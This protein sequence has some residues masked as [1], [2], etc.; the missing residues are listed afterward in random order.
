MDLERHVRENGL[1]GILLADRLR[2]QENLIARVKGMLAPTG[3][4]QAS[5]GRSIRRDHVE[6]SVLAQSSRLARVLRRAWTAK[7]LRGSLLVPAAL[8]NP[9]HGQTATSPCHT[10]PTAENTQLAFLT[11][12]REP[13]S[14]LSGGCAGRD[15]DVGP[16]TDTTFPETSISRRRLQDGI[17]SHRHI[18]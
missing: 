11:A 10:S 4:R 14:S 1:T 13:R 2:A 16:G 5:S 12:D 6:H 7:R 18:P 15:W 9:L 17:R 3:T 8:D